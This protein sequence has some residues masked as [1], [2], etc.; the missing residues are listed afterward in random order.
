[1]AFN[2]PTI[3]IDDFYP[4]VD[5]VREFALQQQYEPSDGG[6]WPG[7]RTK[8]IH[9]LDEEFYHYFTQRVMSVFYN[10]GS[11]DVTWN[12]SSNFQRF[13]PYSENA[14]SL[15]NV[16]WTHRDTALF[17][18]VIYLTPNPNPDSGT[19]IFHAK[20]DILPRI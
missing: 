12:I 18:G 17:A 7:E 8:M 15:T 14:S 1:M 11:E 16:G 3:C 10:F 4:N 9:E 5:R 2:F 19:S 13:P 6:F 20:K